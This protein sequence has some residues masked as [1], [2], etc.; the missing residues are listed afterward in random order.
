VA[1]STLMSIGVR[2]M[3]ASQAA[4]QTT[5]HNIANA[6]VEGYSRQQVELETSKGQFSGA[7]F[8]GKGVNVAS[9]TRA[10]DA[11]LTREAATA[12]ALA[13]MDSARRDQL[14]R[15][16]EA[17]PVG[18]QGIGHAAGQF[19][20]AMV[21]VASN[22]QDL[23]A[24][25]V[26]LARAQELTAR[27][28]QAGSQLDGLQAGVTQDLE[29]SVASVNSLA[30]RI[31]EVNQQIA[32]ARGLDHAPNDLLD[33][34][35]QLVKE[36]SGLVQVS[37]IAADDG[38]L[39]VFIG[40]GQRLVLGNQALQLKLVPDAADSSRSA[41]SI[42]EHGSERPLDAGALSGGAIAGLLRFQNEDLVQARAE[43]GRMAVSLSMA[44]NEQQSLGTDLR[45]A[46]AQGRPQAGGLMFTDFTQPQA[47]VPG[48]GNAR[49]GSGAPLAA[50]SLTVEDASLLRAAEY[51]LRYDGTDWTLRST[52][53]PNF[54]PMAYTPGQTVDGFRLD[55]APGSTPAAGDRFLLQPV[56]RA[57]NAMGMQLTDP[58]GIAAA[59]PLAATTAAANTGT[60]AVA[61]LAITDG[62]FDPALDA[63]VHF[64]N[65]NGD[66]ELRDSAN[67][68]LASGT[69][70]PPAPIE[71]AGAGFAL[72]LTGI[73]AAGDVVQVQR[74]AFPSANNG[75]ALA[76]V[77]LRDAALV[78]RKLD[79][80]GNPGGG[81]SITNAYASAIAGIGV[82][83]Q[84]AQAAAQM[85][86]S[87]AEAAETQRNAASGVNLD[88][89]AARL[90]QYQQSYQA[91]AKILQVAQ[92]V[93]DS[94]LRAADG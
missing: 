27:F 13:S 7:G 10:H 4:L 73:P 8:F 84:G 76:M 63:Q 24:R 18:E 56:T 78:G 25:N 49:D 16:E 79:A 88:E 34:R 83:V 50:V 42:V 30:E 41:L 54:A 19:L 37:T 59:S 60:A 65:G 71:P 92:S 20:N 58:R 82:R 68:V 1:V 46:D 15:L 5:G 35:D 9:V 64:T 57:A 53:D 85:S 23:S 39:G 48:V 6:S 14:T 17:F 33:R 75:N 3:F 11:F 29:N 36:L 40:G 70:A 87:L 32:L 90:M 77:D 74:T 28:T 55:L 62:G 12:Q 67:T 69:W 45:P 91:A 44:V 80:S 94:L 93:F 89:E 31:A 26:V 43:L 21:D 86:G 72:Q 81:D 66:W 22:P 61:S 52:T 51:E 47:G 2:A 38:T